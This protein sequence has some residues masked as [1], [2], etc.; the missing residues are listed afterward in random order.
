MKPV[1]AV[2]LGA[3]QDLAQQQLKRPDEARL[4]PEISLAPVTRTAEGRELVKQMINTL[5]RSI[6][7][8]D[9]A[10]SRAADKS[11]TRRSGYA[12]NTLEPLII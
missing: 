2:A 11:M 1:T 6:L 4:H 8:A 10:L 9:S 3:V 7:V 5:L 12:S